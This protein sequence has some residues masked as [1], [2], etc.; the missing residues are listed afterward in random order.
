MNSLS[1]LVNSYLLTNPSP[2]ASFRLGRRD[3]RRHDSS[4]HSH[5]SVQPA[6]PGSFRGDRLYRE[7][8]N[9]PKG[10]TSPQSGPVPAS[11]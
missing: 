3:G 10:R 7:Y 6:Q 8:S 2:S 4:F 5:H 9:A 1:Q 11:K